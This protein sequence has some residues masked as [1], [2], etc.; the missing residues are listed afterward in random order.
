MFFPLYR[1]TA[2]PILPVY[3][4]FKIDLLVNSKPGNSSTLVGCLGQGRS[5]EN[6]SFKFSSKTA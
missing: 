6:R 2:L 5:F 3:S 1:L 4:I